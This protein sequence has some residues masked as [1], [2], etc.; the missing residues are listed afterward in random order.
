MQQNLKSILALEYSLLQLT[1]ITGAT[2]ATKLIMPPASQLHLRFFDN[3]NKNRC[4]ERLNGKYT[5]PIASANRGKAYLMK[6]CLKNIAHAR[7]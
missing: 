3:S 7:Y 5:T 2:D 4:V 1:Q 6:C